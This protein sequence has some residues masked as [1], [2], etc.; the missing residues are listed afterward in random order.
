M[1]KTLTINLNGY[2]FNIDEDAYQVLNQYLEDLGR[3]FAADEKEEIL[4]DIEARVAELFSEKLVNR[5]VVELRDVQEVIEQLGQPNEFEDE[6]G[7]QTH[8]QTAEP[9]QN[10]TAGERRKM[11][12]LY[13]DTANKRLGGV[14]AGLAAYMDWDPTLV[15]ILFLLV[16]ILSLGWTVFIYILMW[17][18]IPEANSVAQRLEMQGV[19]PTAENIGSYAATTDTTTAS[20]PSPLAKILKVIAIVV[21]SIIGIGLFASVM[22]VL[23]ATIMLVFHLLPIAVSLNE[24]LLLASI[25]LFLIIPAIAIVMFCVYL[26]GNRKPR[27]KWAAWVLLGLWLASIVGISVFGVNA[28]NHRDKWDSEEIKNGLLKYWDDDDTDYDEQYYS[29]EDRNNG[30]FHAIDA[31]EAITVKFTQGDSTSVEVKAPQSKIA[32]IRT[33]I[34]NGVL[35]IRNENQNLKGNQHIIVYVTAPQLDKIKMSEACNFECEGDVNFPK[36]EVLLEEASRVKLAGK[37]DTLN[38]RAEEA[39]HA[40]L[41]DVTADVATIRAEEASHVAMG[42]ARELRIQTTEASAVTYKGVPQLLQKSSSEF[43]VVTKR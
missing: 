40:D 41:E 34:R 16:M 28:Y 25:G 18:F 24:I 31:E 10:F 19:E 42:T 38:V 29:N 12:K 5:N 30:D 8:T 11:R 4:K 7:T 21:L 1:K 20:T 36:L 14:A 9:Q 43:S 3:H 17:I 2:V 15:R 22:G 33:D 39:A 37:I 27:H 13:R 6:S 35:Y 32:N 23:I 26:V